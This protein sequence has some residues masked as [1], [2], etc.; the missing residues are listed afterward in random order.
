MN[1]AAIPEYFGVFMMP[2]KIRNMEDILK[3]ITHFSDQAHGEQLRK[4]APDR[5]IVHPLRVME[6]LK[7]YTDDISVLAAALLHDVLEDTPVT[8]EEM[9][10]FLKLHLEE[11][12]AERTLGLVLE[13]T[14]VYLK[15]DFPKLN[16]KS[17]KEKELQRLTGISPD[18]QTI[19][20]A[21][22]MDNAQEISEED[23]DFSLVYLGEVRKII[24]RLNRGNIVLREK[25]LVVV[26][27]AIAG[28]DSK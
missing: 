17:R 20:Y 7:A 24:S 19:K 22:I 12:Q 15:T 27:K 11:E 1:F 5:Y 13:L 18:A 6:T 4:Y 3:H 8:A 2:F 28:L 9:R 14:D 23:T 21:D 16:R 26:E 10:R 25:A